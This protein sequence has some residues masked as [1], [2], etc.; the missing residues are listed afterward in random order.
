MLGYILL[1]LLAALVLLLAVLVVR[2][3][4]FRPLAEPPVEDMPVEVDGDRAAE[5]LAAMVRCK[6]VS[7]RDRSMVDDKEFDRFRQLLI[8]SLSA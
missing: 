4:R 2:T 5:S 6:T 7:S 3:L 1:T 8:A